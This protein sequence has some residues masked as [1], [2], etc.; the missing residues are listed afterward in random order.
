MKPSYQIKK[1]NTPSSKIMRMIVFKKFFWAKFQTNENNKQQTPPVFM[2][3]L[4][5]HLSV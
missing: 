1:Q 2:M 4:K 5:Q 3:Q